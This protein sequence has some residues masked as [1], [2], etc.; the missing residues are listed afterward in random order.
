MFL[1]RKWHLYWHY[2]IISI[3]G[4]TLGLH[5]DVM[6]HTILYYSFSDGV[7]IIILFCHGFIWHIV[8]VSIFIPVKSHGF[9]VSL[10]V[11]AMKSLSHADYEISHAFQLLQNLRNK[12]YG[13]MNKP[14][15]PLVWVLVVSDLILATWMLTQNNRYPVSM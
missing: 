7:L 3:H 10:T 4:T 11:L 8:K 1:E 14:I 5:T 13:F 2:D 15:K 12:Y 6:T 9:A